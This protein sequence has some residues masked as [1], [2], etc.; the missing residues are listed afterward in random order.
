MSRGALSR[1]LLSRPAREPALADV[2][3]R[4]VVTLQG[5]TGDVLESPRELCRGE[6]PVGEH[7]A[8]TATEPGVVGGG[9]FLH[10]TE[11]SKEGLRGDG[12]RGEVD[13]DAVVVVVG[14]G[15]HG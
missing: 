1:L 9:D 2:A 5:A 14:E 11:Q 13:G 4:L 10:L 7:R 3:G 15:R 6:V 8:E 12:V